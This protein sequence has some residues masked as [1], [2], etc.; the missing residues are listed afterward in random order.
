MKVKR[1]SEYGSGVWLISLCLAYWAARSSEVI[2]LHELGHWMF[3]GG[4][5]HLDD[6][7]GYVYGGAGGYLVDIGGSVG[8]I[9][10]FCFFG[11]LARKLLP[12]LWAVV[13]M[14]SWVVAGFNY[15]AGVRPGAD[16]APGD[17][18]YL[19]GILVAFSICLYTV[20]K[21][22]TTAR[23]WPILKSEFAMAWRLAKAD[24]YGRQGPLFRSKRPR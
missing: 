12:P 4:E 21:P 24:D 19:G 5:I 8:P 22:S 6:F 1:F 10:L 11:R 9:V 17:P 14:V 7:G 18:L 15:D 2:W 13:G 3:G 20:L 16:Y 23:L